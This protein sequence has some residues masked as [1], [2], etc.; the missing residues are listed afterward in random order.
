MTE[1]SFTFDPA[2]DRSEQFD[3]RDTPSGGLPPG[4]VV[5]IGMDAEWIAVADD[6]RDL[7]LSRIFEE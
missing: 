3:T 6:W 2:V 4:G 7:P 5:F 1:P